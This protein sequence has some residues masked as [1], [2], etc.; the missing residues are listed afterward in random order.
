MVSFG[1]TDEQVIKRLNKTN[2]RKD[3]Y[4][5]IT[6]MKGQGRAVVFDC[7]ATMLRLYN[8][9]KY[10]E[11]YGSLSHEIFHIVSF[12][13]YRIGQPLEVRVSDEAYAYLIGYLTKE[14]YKKINNA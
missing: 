3:E 11:D 12:V 1:E 10:P 4:H 6:E 7:G 13:M 9:P 14:I 8:Y 2:V 5:L